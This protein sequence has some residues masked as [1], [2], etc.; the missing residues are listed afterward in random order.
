MERIILMTRRSNQCRLSV[1]LGN[2]D[3]QHHRSVSAEILFR[4]ERAGIWG[5]TT[6]QGIEG[7]GQS[8]KIHDKPVWTLVD[9]TPI[10]V[11]LIDTHERIRQF[12]PQL[13]EFADSCLVVYDDVEVVTFGGSDH[14]G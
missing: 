9:R 5:A 14:P 3:V 4:A 13:A 7:Y 10:T 11:H 12:L 1:Y 8:R 2:A 6:L